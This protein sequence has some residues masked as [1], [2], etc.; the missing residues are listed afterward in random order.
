MSPND[1]TLCP[2]AE[3]NNA[4]Q[5]THRKHSED[6]RTPSSRPRGND[7]KH[8]RRTPARKTYQCKPEQLHVLCSHC[9]RSSWVS[10]SDGTTNR[11][12]LRTKKR[13]KRLASQ[14]FLES[15][16]HGASKP[17]E[18]ANNEKKHA[19]W[20]SLYKTYTHHSCIDANARSVPY[21]KSR[22]VTTLPETRT[23]DTSVHLITLMESD[24][25]NLCHPGS[26]SETVLNCH[27]SNRLSRLRDGCVKKK[28]SRSVERRSYVCPL[29]VGLMDFVATNETK[30]IEKCH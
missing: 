29:V 16:A 18:D 30:E 13:T 28:M 2:A 7:R 9:R 19:L 14:V 23:T 3:H 5:R 20:D 26:H 11:F 22:I 8:P 17:N 15:L 6:P 27:L 24:K 10:S 21:S 12:D 4:S 1:K 25:N